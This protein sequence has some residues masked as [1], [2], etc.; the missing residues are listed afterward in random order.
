LRDLPFLQEKLEAFKRDVWETLDKWV[1]PGLKD[2][3]GESPIQLGD[4]VGGLLFNVQRHDMSLR[5]D[6]ASTIVSMSLVEGLVKQLDPGFD[7]V[8]TAIPY[9]NYFPPPLVDKTKG[10]LAVKNLSV[11]SG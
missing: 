10:F 8:A 3:D 4:V 7:I 1:G 5:G 9:F 6:V 11:N 2:P